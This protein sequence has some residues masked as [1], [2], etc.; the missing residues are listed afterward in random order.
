MFLGGATLLGGCQGC[1]PNPCSEPNPPNE[2]NTP[3]APNAPNACGTG[4]YGMSPTQ[5]TFQSGGSGW[6]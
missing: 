1:E 4:G 3:N 5:A 6:R 2:C